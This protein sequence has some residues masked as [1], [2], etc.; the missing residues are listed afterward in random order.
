MKKKI[1]LILALVMIIST[2]SAC[3]F[4]CTNAKISVYSRFRG[5]F[6]PIEEYEQ[7][8]EIE[9]EPDP[10]IYKARVGAKIYDDD[11]RILWVDDDKIVIR[12]Y[13]EFI[14]VDGPSRIFTINRGEE[15]SI[16]EYG[17]C[18]ASNTYWIKYLDE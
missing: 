2:F 3:G 10:V 12:M 1:A 7:Q 16:N 8:I 18:D 6:L 13:T 11:V 17:L 14:G 9:E 5:E 15:I 4:M